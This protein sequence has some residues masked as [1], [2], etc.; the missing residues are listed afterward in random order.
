MSGRS[1]LK[2]NYH[3]VCYHFKETGAISMPYIL[4]S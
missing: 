4:S 3:V 1:T 2:L